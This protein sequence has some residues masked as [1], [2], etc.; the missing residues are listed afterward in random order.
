MKGM[1]FKWILKQ[2]ARLPI[3]SILKLFL[4]SSI[5]GFCYIITVVVLQDEK[6]LKLLLP[7]PL[8]KF[9][10]NNADLNKAYK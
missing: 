7:R 2:V 6:K 5:N 8:P 3:D 9:F 4:S 10:T 1:F